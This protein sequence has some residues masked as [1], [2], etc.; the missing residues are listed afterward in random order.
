MTKAKTTSV[1]TV[2]F[3]DIPVGQHVLSLQVEALKTLESSLGASFVSAVEILAKAKGRV[4]VTGVGKSGHVARKMS[5]TFASTGTPAQ[6]VHAAEA[7]H[8][9]MGMITD[10][11][12]IIALSNSGEAKELTDMVNYAKRY[13]IPLLGMTS[14][15][16][17]TL[18]KA[19][20]VPLVMPTHKEGCSIGMAPTTSTT[21]MMAYGDALAV[22]LMERRGFSKEDFGVFHPGGKLGQQLMRVS[23]LMHQDDRLPV[24]TESDAMSHV[25]V[26]MT[27]KALG[28]AGVTNA[29]GVLIGIVTDGDLRRHMS[30]DLVSKTAGEVMSPNPVTISPEKLASEALGLMQNNEKN[31]PISAIFATVDRKPV[32]LLHLHDCLRVGL[33]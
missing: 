10:Q 3:Q 1:D 8:G 5:A 2:S 11:D 7:S 32:G 18:A 28:C 13:G 26:V 12:V 17:S 30:D 25:M 16:E 9:D 22:A 14:K 23:E 20:D 6:F 15:A 19:S 29:D 4:I 24:V 33:A 21:L 31:R 27:E